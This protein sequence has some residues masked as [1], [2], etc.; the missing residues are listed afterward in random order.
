[1]CCWWQFT[2][3]QLQMSFLAS[4]WKACKWPFGQGWSTAIVVKIQITELLSL[5]MV[6]L[7][8]PRLSFRMHSCSA[9]SWLVYFILALIS[10][11]K[12]QT[13]DHNLLWLL[14]LAGNLV[15]PPKQSQRMKSDAFLLSVW[16]TFT[17][18]LSPSTEM[19]LTCTV[20]LSRPKASF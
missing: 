18:T 11:L 5:Q 15:Q 4:L 17:C 9:H 6:P 13:S 14:R 7:F 19:V 20:S 2:L 3:L 1:M 16:L 8:Q 12:F 10:A